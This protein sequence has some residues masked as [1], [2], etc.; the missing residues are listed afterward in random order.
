MQSIE[1][2]RMMYSE[3]LKKRGSLMNNDRKPYGLIAVIGKQE[4][5]RPALPAEFAGKQEVTFFSEEIPYYADL[6]IRDNVQQLR[7]MT[8]EKALALFEEL[9]TLSG[10][11]NLSEWKQPFRKD[12]TGQKRLFGIFEAMITRPD[13]LLVFDL[14]A[15]MEANQ[16]EAFAKMADRYRENGGKLVYTAQS[17]KD[18][19]RLELS[20]EVWLTGKDGFIRTDTETVNAKCAALAATED[21]DEQYRRMEAGETW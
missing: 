7:M 5:L 10:L 13:L 6:S 21:I 18:V 2:N 4:T 19:M 9:L 20:Q 1:D 12:M 14:L 3:I 15:G 17:L 11:Q 16:R 8:G